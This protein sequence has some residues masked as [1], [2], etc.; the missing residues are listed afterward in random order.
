MDVPQ[1]S[2]RHIL[3]DGLSAIAFVLAGEG[4]NP[5]T[6]TVTPSPERVIPPVALAGQ[7]A[8]RWAVVFAP[9][10]VQ[11]EVLGAVRPPAKN[12]RHDDTAYAE[13]GGNPIPP[14]LL[15]HLFSACGED[16]VLL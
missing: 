10:N 15:M 1:P 13:L 7:H 11:A 9:S 14:L 16:G 2:P 12:Q 4:L 8:Q 6:A 3:L 5:P